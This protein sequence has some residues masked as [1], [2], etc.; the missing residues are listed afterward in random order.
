MCPVQRLIWQ[1]SVRVPQQGRLQL[2]LRHRISK[3]RIQCSCLRMAVWFFRHCLVPRRI[4]QAS[5]L[6]WLGCNIAWTLGCQFQTTR[7]DLQLRRSEPEILRPRPEG[8]GLQWGGAG[9][10]MSPGVP[11]DPGLLS[12]DFLLR[13]LL[14]G[15]DRWWTSQQL[16]TWWRTSETGLCRMTKMKK[17]PAGKCHQHSTNCFVRQWHLRYVSESSQSIPHGPGWWR[18]DRVS[19]L[20]QPS[21]TDTMTSTAWIDLGLKENEEVE[22]TTLS[23][24]LN[25]DS[26]T[27][28]HLT[29]KQ[30]FPREPYRL[31]VHRDAQYLPKPPAADGFDS[32]KSPAS[33]QISHGMNLDTE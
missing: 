3:D 12:E 6:W 1:L 19:W 13:S 8:P 33:Y 28:K 24:S 30:I 10:W 23:E 16:S 31:K 32:N 18:S 11:H 7:T 17:D 20:V 26:S 14:L 22:K 29:V 15:M 21:L 4:N 9:R 27:F 5:C 25:T 2:G